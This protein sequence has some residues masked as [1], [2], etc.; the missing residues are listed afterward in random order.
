MSTGA[1][2]SVEQ[3]DGTYTTIY[4]HSD[5]YPSYLGEKLLHHYNSEQLANALVALGDASFIDDKLAPD[6]EHPTHPVHSFG[7]PQNGVCMFYNR[8]RGEPWAETKLT[9]HET[10]GRAIRNARKGMDYLY[11]FRESKWFVL[12]TFFRSDELTELTEE[13]IKND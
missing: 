13:R 12:D 4:N 2:I 9:V 6:P 7:D 1:L 11:V 3:Q 10:L 8:D 5:G